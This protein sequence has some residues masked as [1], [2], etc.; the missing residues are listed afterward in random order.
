VTQTFAPWLV[1]RV[2]LVA[3]ESFAR[4]EWAVG[5]VPVEDGQGKEVLLRVQVDSPSLQSH[6]T[7]YTDSNGREM[8]KRVRDQR[9]TWPLNVT[10]PVAQ[11]YYPVTSAIA[12]RD[13]SDKTDYTLQDRGVVTTAGSAA[14]SA[15]ASSHLHLSLLPD[16]PQGCSSLMDGALECV[17]HRRLLFDDGKGVAEPLNETAF[18][19]PYPDFVRS[20]PGLIVRGEHWMQLQQRENGW[21]GM[22]IAQQQNEQPLLALFAPLP[23]SISVSEY[24]SSYLLND[25]QLVTAL[26]PNVRLLTL[27]ERV[28]RSEGSHRTTRSGKRTPPPQLL[29]R[30]AHTFSVGEDPQWSQPA[31]VDLGNLLR[32]RN[33]K[34]SGFTEWNLSGSFPLEP[35]QQQSQGTIGSKG[36]TASSTRDTSM[37]ITLQPMQIRTFMLLTK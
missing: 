21:A 11:N 5:E 15:Q 25:S 9:P 28:V 22:R 4:V 33:S 20:G 30:L 13:E 10:E 7:F 27:Q 6:A 14:S 8:Q 29:V 31:E 36:N 2:R 35:S 24:A 23:P 1:S 19:S 26:P 16:R 18:I 32:L 34:I 17:V 3:G 12:L 37:L